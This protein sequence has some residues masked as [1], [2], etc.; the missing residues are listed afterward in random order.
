MFASESHFVWHFLQVQ[1]SHLQL[2]THWSN[3]AGNQ[4]TLGTK[5]DTLE[6]WKEIIQLT[7]R[8]LFANGYTYRIHT[9]NCVSIPCIIFVKIC[10]ILI[11]THDF[12]LVLICLSNYKN[13]LQFWLYFNLVLGKSRKTASQEKTITCCTKIFS[14]SC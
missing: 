5:T 1:I 13:L 10:L 6:V 8:I 14:L 11:D 2:N 9:W 4:K 7:L 3:S 12:S